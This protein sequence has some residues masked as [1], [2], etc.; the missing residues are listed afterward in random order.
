MLLYSCSV[1]AF[2]SHA[3]CR[4]KSDTVHVTL[5][6]PEQIANILQIE[7]GM[8]KKSSEAI[9]GQIVPGCHKQHRQGRSVMC[10]SVQEPGGMCE[11]GHVIECE[12]Y[13]CLSSIHVDSSFKR[14]E[15]KPSQ[16]I[17]VLCTYALK[18][19]QH[20]QMCMCIGMLPKLLSSEPEFLSK[21]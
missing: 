5:R 3:C 1:P 18:C 20:A 21:I 7:A 10:L 15:T 13:S 14:L 19:V 16:D 4:I 17:Y 11:F 6:L 2:Q 9:V 8:K 12:L